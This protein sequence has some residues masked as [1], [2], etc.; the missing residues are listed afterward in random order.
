MFAQTLQIA[1]LVLCQ[2]RLYLYIEI[3]GRYFKCIYPSSLTYKGTGMFLE[4]VKYKGN[5]VGVEEALNPWKTKQKKK[6]VHL[7][8]STKIKDCS[9]RRYLR[10]MHIQP[11]I[12]GQEMGL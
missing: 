3:T 7:I 12:L 5:N 4:M 11:D 1:I 10:R 8:L 2:G 6:Q 9:I